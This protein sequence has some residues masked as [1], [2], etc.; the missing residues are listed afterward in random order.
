MT[1]LDKTPQWIN[2]LLIDIADELDI[3]Q[4]EFEQ[5]QISYNSLAKWLERPDSSVRQFVPDIYPQGSIKYGTVIKPLDVN[6]D[7]DV[8][9]V[10][11]LK[12][13]STHQVSQKRLK[14]LVGEEILRYATTLRMKTKPENKRRCWTIHYSEGLRFHLDT[15]PAVPADEEVKQIFEKRG[16]HRDLVKAAISITDSESDNYDVI[17]PDWN[18]SN[19]AG[20][21]DW[22]YSRMKESRDFL[23]QE[24]AKLAEAEQ[25]PEFRLRTTLQQTIQLLKRHRDTLFGDDEEKPISIIITTLA[26]KAY[27]NEPSI[28]DALVNVLRNME[29]WIRQK[30]DDKIGRM[31]DWVEN[32]VDPK[33]NFADRWVEHPERRDLF[34]EWLEQART[35]FTEIC[36]GDN[37]QL[38]QNL[39]DSR[40]GSTI[41]KKAMGRNP[42]L[43]TESQ[44]IASPATIAPVVDSRFDVPHRKSPRWPI[45]LSHSVGISGEAKRH[46]FRTRHLKGNDQ[47]LPKYIDLYFT[48]ETNV[49]PPYDVYWQ[50]VNTGAEASALGLKGLRGNI[51][52]GSRIR[53]ENTKYR[54][55]HWIECFIVKDNVCIARSGEFVVN[56]K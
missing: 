8:D 20:Y 2:Q 38:V 14:D 52:I 34:F 33:E 28:A 13:L 40:M 35:Y 9:L 15:L 41:V 11:V 49:S 30:T 37:V 54:G 46:G 36:Q 51:F 21:A 27:S 3:S 56:I 25:L 32:P 5:A 19:P 45:Q 24:N 22:F 47:I 53:K 55:W 31:V 10:L 39:L 26:A 44:R 17:D 43:Y 1:N 16:V 42:K 23:L 6:G 50:V 18:H 48:A 4:S 12:E 29:Q 7:Y